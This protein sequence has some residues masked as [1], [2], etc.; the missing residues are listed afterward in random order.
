[1]TPLYDMRYEP[2][3]PVHYVL[4][5]EGSPGDP[6]F[7]LGVPVGV[8]REQAIALARHRGWRVLTA[9]RWRSWKPRASWE[10][11]A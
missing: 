11:Q 7:A 1:M 8:T 5:V 4:A 6:R 9:T 3:G 2:P 10:Q